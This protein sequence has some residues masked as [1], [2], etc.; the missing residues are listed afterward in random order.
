M[1]SG[2]EV[3]R[4]ASPARDTASI[5]QLIAAFRGRTA[6]VGV[7]GLGY[8]GL[9]LACTAAR[10]GFRVL[11]FDVDDFK[12]KQLQAGKSYIRHIEEEDIAGFRAAGGCD[13]TTDFSRAFEPDALLL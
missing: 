13:A 2:L 3:V 10:K 7:V 4:V 11:G 9:P 12:V 5:E 6:T 8:V 1:D